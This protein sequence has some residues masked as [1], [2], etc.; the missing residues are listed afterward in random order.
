MKLAIIDT[1]DQAYEQTVLLTVGEDRI[2]Y[3]RHPTD[4]ALAE[5]RTRLETGNSA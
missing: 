5:S 4:S 3:T 2:K 1:L